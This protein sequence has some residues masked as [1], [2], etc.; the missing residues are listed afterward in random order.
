MLLTNV[1]E[2][3]EGIREAH[4]DGAV[5][6][7]E[8]YNPFLCDENCANTQTN[9]K[10]RCVLPSSPAQPQTSYRNPFIDEIKVEVVSRR[11]LDTA[12]VRIVQLPLYRQLFGVLIQTPFLLLM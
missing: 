12:G 7:C 4:E 5:T 3:A 1:F 2:G 9:G 10:E 11:G 6:K 8:H